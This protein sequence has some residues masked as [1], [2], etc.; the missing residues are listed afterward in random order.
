MI[1]QS[2]NHHLDLSEAISLASVA[3]V[4]LRLSG[5]VRASL[6]VTRVDEMDEG[7]VLAVS[8]GLMPGPADEALQVLEIEASLQHL[9]DLA[10]LRAIA[11]RYDIQP[12]RLEAF[13]PTEPAL[14]VGLTPEE[15]DAAL[16]ALQGAIIANS[17]PMDSPVFRAAEKLK[18]LVQDMRKARVR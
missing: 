18:A 12:E 16:D 13:L 1:E 10:Q 11:R 6:L 8:L 2:I 9:L 5:D 7:G 14:E 17:P 15:A 3:A 4:L